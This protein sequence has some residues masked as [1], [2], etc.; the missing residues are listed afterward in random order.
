M[1]ELFKFKLPTNQQQA[2][3]LFE[4]NQPPRFDTRWRLHKVNIALWPVHL[5]QVNDW[6]VRM[7]IPEIPFS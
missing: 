1:S 7:L 2:T 3:P 4:A 6:N 5:N